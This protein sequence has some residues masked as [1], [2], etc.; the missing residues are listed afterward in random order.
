MVC[1]CQLCVDIIKEVVES[2]K[3]IIKYD[4]SGRKW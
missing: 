1:Y 3:K 4:I 2:G